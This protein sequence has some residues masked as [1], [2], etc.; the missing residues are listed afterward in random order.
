M[1]TVTSEEASPLRL[2]RDQ[3]SERCGC[4]AKLSGSEL[5]RLLRDA[6][7]PT[8]GGASA[9]LEFADC[10]VLDASNDR[11]LATVDFGPL[12]G[13]DLSRAGRIAAAHALSDVYAVGGRPREALAM[14]IVDPRLPQR[15]PSDVLAGMGAAC[16]RDD[17][18]L[19][20]GHTV[21]GVEA[22]AGLSV[23]GV[24]PGPLLT[25]RGAR[26]G[27]ELLVSKPVGLG[28]AVR[29]YRAGELDDAALEPALAV[30]ETSNRQAARAATDAGVHAATDI[31]GFGLLGHLTEMLGGGRLGA[32]LELHAVPVVEV[33]KYL[34]RHYARSAWI[35]DNFDYC[36]QSINLVGVRD[37]AAIA[38]LLDPQT[39]GGLL[40]S[41]PA[42]RVTLLQAAGFQRIGEVTG[43][44]SLEI[45][46]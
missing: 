39:S 16:R 15:A 9:H 29:A 17:V 37:R 20:G 41:A 23:L 40:V 43:M 38:P 36:R 32:R 18:R 19:V 14:L 45:V 1:K 13:P 2:T 34:P 7:A 35:D 25:K 31:T 11:L 44:P 27:D 46:G 22:M 21:V 3:M 42:N 28:M 33:T 12:V 8:V 5:R 4:Q 26:P 10:A 6:F 24:A 30:M